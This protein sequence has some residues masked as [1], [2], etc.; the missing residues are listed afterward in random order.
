[1][2]NYLIPAIVAII[3]IYA[4][5]K[6]IDIFD[7]FLHGVKEG[8]KTSINLFP[9]IFA[10]ILA[11]TLLT[12]S[13]IIN[14]L[15]SYLKP[16]FDKLNFPIETLPLAILRPISGS[17]SLIILDSIIAKYGADSF[18]GIL[19]SVMQGSTDTT[20][21]IIGMYFASI[22]I[23]KIRYSLVVGLLADLLSIII[24]LLVVTIYFS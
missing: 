7:S 3:L 24:S 10:M 22:G 5:S 12:Q 13:N 14:E 23:K 8:I 16:I 20:I 17:S 1:M 9:T 6:K 21:Y 11:I 19:S 15:S 18:I 2:S 4:I